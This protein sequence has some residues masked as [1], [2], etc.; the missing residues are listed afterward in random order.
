MNIINER[1]SA[2]RTLMKEKGIDMYYIPTSDYHDSEYVN[3]FF[4]GRAWM[5]GFTG[6][7]GT[8]IVTKE[9]AG[10]FTDG[11][12]FIQAEKELEGSGII[13]F[14]T[15]T[16][17]VPTVEEYCAVYMQKHNV[18]GFDGRTVTK[19]FV[20]AIERKM[21][22]KKLTCAYEEDLAG[23]I[24][25]DRPEL[26]AKPVSI[27]DERYAG[28]PVSEKLE[29]IRKIMKEKGAESH[30]LTSLDDIEAIIDWFH[31]NHIDYRGLIPMGLANDA[32]GL[33]IY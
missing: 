23:S 3:P 10:L 33:N 12:Y 9:E 6:S 30:L 31:K 18:I 24:W 27:L 14:R 4:R 26:S 13:L 5:S 1:V 20:D 32:T 28:E 2:L 17:G 19:Q 22:G 21:N 29:R 11:R 25:S 16:A 7:A 8:L 15:G